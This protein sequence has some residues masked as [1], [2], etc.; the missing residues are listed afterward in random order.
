MEV[1]SDSKL[2]VR[3]Q[4]VVA[5]NRVYSPSSTLEFDWANFCKEPLLQSIYAETLRLH[6]AIFILRSSD[7]EDVNVRGWRIPRNGP[8]L[9]AGYNE[10]M[11]PEQWQSKS[12]PNAKLVHEFWA[13]RF[14]HS[15]PSG[16]DLEF[17]LK[18]RCNTWLPYGGGQ[19]MCP[20]RHFAKL[21]MISSLA[22]ILT[23]FD[24]DIAD[25]ASKIP[26]NSMEGLG[27]GALWPKGNLRV[28]VRRRNN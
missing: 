28:R 10:Q 12:Q 14:L 25:L 2:L 21:E 7:R 1:I 15:C 9:I 17:S 11:D 24:V 5:R 18:G 22:I 4:E 19:R 3:I 23:L 26:E 27:F 20:G 13:E 6:I 16:K 8:I